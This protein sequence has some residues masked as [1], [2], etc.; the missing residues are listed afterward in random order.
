MRAKGLPI[1]CQSDA[2]RVVDEACRE[3]G[4]QTSL[5]EELVEL[6]RD[7]I[8][9]GRR[10]GITDGLDA[11]LGERLTAEEDEQLAS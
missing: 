2:R 10:D 1:F 8:G 6:E 3:Y 9:M 5:L 7:H 11:I 4:I